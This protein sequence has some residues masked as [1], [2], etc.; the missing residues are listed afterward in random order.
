MTRVSVAKLENLSGA[1][2]ALVSTA[3]FVLATGQV[4]EFVKWLED[5]VG[6]D[7]DGPYATADEIRDRLDMAIMWG[8][9]L[10]DA[11]DDRA[12]E[13]VAANGGGD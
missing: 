6:E 1:L 11:L 9:M 12:L 5:N 2:S 3:A 8:D 7:Y 4:D 13:E 10:S